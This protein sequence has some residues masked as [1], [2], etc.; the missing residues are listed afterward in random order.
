MTDPPLV[1]GDPSDGSD[2]QAAM[3]D[4]MIGSAQE[5]LAKARVR[6]E[7]QRYWLRLSACVAALSVVILAVYM[8]WLILDYIMMPCSKADGLFYVL[9]VSPV[10][11]ITLIVI[12]V[13]ISVFRGF[14]ENDLNKV[15]SEAAFKS[16]FGNG[17]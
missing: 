15:P 5:Q 7:R 14:H 9:A 10:V 13:L 2:H 11:S 12:T 4:W 8:V 16:A 1:M 3:E 6:M 17:S